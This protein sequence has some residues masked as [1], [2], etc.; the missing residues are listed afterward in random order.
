LFNRLMQPGELAW[1]D[2]SP[3]YCEPPVQVAVKT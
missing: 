1:L 3:R 2:A